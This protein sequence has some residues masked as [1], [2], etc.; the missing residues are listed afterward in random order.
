[1]KHGKRICMF[2]LAL[3][4]C[5]AVGLL[6]ART[7]PAKAAT[8]VDSGYCGGEGDGTNLTWTLDSDGLL[9][10]SGKGSMADYTTDRD[11]SLN[12]FTTAPWGKTY[13]NSQRVK[14]VFVD[15][16]VKSIGNCVFYNCRKLTSIILPDSLT[17]IGGSAF[18]NCRRLLSITIPS[19]II[20]IPDYTFFGCS[21][22]SNIEIPDSVINIGPNSLLDTAWYNSQE[23]GLVYAG[24]IAYDYKGT[25]PEHTGIVLKDGTLGIAHEAFQNCDNL[26]SITIPNG[27]I[28]I[29]SSAFNSCDR[30]GAITIPDSV[31]TIGLFAF[32]NCKG[33]KSVIIGNNVTEIPRYA[34]ADCGLLDTVIIGNHVTSI[35][36]S[37]FYNCERLTSVVIPDSVISI[38]DNAFGYC[39][40]L[41]TVVVPDS[42]IEIGS[43][44]FSETAWYN[45]QPDGLVYAGKIAYRMKGVAI[46]NTELIL[47]EDTLGIAGEAFHGQK[48]SYLSIFRKV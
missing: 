14:N 41:S 46:D 31:K 48:V 20:I 3:V 1:M 17:S 30:L 37:A 9:T 42:V 43:F 7:L 29:G 13:A 2:T 16:G 28:F 40:K 8:I 39:R 21:S 24:K 5:C 27:V 47:K 25:M 10:I 4:L 45:E 35:G 23:N 36:D 38:E 33:L 19:G 12:Y 32:R 26:T 11:S 18:Y 15:N 44:V 6:L 22:L 34:F